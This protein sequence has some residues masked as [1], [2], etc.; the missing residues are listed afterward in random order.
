MSELNKK[1][2]QVPP[3]PLILQCGFPLS[4]KILHLSQLP[5]TQWVLNDLQSLTQKSHTLWWEHGATTPLSLPCCCT[6][7]AEMLE[8]EIIHLISIDS[9][10]TAHNYHRLGSN[11]KLGVMMSFLE[12]QLPLLQAILSVPWNLIKHATNLQ[13]FTD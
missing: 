12:A 5:C 10:T 7:Q 13:Q 6:A 2:S 1:T 11:A 9:V 8:I 4:Y 3:R